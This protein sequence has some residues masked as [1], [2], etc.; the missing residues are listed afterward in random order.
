MT[1]CAECMHLDEWGYCEIWGGGV[2][3]D[4]SHC[5]HF[6]QNEVRE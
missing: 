6:T 3:E 2:C 4:D 5:K 1:T